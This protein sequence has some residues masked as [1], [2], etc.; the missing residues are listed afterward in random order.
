M[1]V[2]VIIPSKD[3]PLINELIQEIHGVL[4]N[5]KHEII[6]VDKSK[7]KPRIKN[8]K[9]LFQE[10]DGLGNAFL[11]G[12]EHASGDLIVLMDADFSHDP[13]DLPKLIKAAKD[14]DIV[15]GSRFLEESK[16]EESFLRLMISMVTNSLTRFIL[17][18]K[19]KDCLSGFSATKRNVF[20]KV[21]LNPL[22]FK[23]NLE[24][25]YKSR[26]LRVNE[27]PIHFHLRKAGKS[28]FGLKEVLR[29]LI[30]LTR[31]RIMKS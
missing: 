4:S 22:G 9:L 14:S 24:L 20:N 2:S 19:V 6:V 7:K 5:L 29:F 18:L 3:E 17:G 15:I 23:I 10:S 8:A 30:L 11:E 13:R 31:L 21:K 27:V 12:L 16:N 25:L 28:K 1:K 26:N